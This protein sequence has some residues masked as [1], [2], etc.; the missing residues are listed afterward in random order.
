M[1]RPHRDLEPYGDID[2]RL[3]R[4]GPIGVRG[5]GS[6]GQPRP[7]GANAMTKPNGWVEM[8][9][10][11]VADHAALVEMSSRAGGIST[12]RSCSASDALPVRRSRRAPQDA[13]D[14]WAWNFGPTA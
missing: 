10:G 1:A 11:N 8:C 12:S 7:A 13:L 4:V 2:V 3:R 9:R 5:A 6:K 14:W